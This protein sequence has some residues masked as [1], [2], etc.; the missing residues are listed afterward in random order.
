MV[1]GTTTIDD[2]NNNNRRRRRQQQQQSTMATTTT[3]TT[4]ATTI[5][6]NGFYATINQARA[7]AGAGAARQALLDRSNSERAAAAAGVSVTH[8]AGGK[9]KKARHVDAQGMMDEFV[10]SVSDLNKELNDSIKAAVAVQPGTATESPDSKRLRKSKA[11]SNEIKRLMEEKSLET[12]PV[13][14]EKLSKKITKMRK[15][16]DEV[17]GDIDE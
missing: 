12:D 9:K 14:V 15:Q 8:H 1:M 16:R 7:S 17:H 13:E 3:T 5:N 6:G 4:T 11:L 10:L 2:D